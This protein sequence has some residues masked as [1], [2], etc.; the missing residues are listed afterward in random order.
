MLKFHLA[1][2]NSNTFIL[3]D[4]L[5][6]KL[7]SEAFQKI[8]AYL[9]Q[10]NRDDALI[11]TDKEEQ[12]SFLIAT[13]RVLGQDNTFA[14]FCGNG[15]L[16]CGAYL[17]KYHPRFTRFSLKTAQGLH[18]LLSCGE[19]IYSITLPLPSRKINPLF[20][21]DNGALCH[22]E[23]LAYVEV[24]EPHLVIEGNYTEEELL[25]KGREL[26]TL[27]SIFPRGINLN[28]YHINQEG[29]CYV[30]TYERGV[31]RLTAA[32]GTGS[33]A[34]AFAL[35]CR[36]TKISTQ[37]GCLEVKLHPHGVELKGSPTLL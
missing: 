9:I 3:V 11:L 4:A 8:H 19:G 36:E 7:N 17:F 32:C 13:M 28:A 33:I 24:I 12:G 31:Q 6:T 25:K 21:A 27:K 29:I 14:E 15:A 23:N 30:K 16:A 5:D 34:C 37:G 35:G 18:P 1:N 2:T 22:K 26:N 10:E 20:I